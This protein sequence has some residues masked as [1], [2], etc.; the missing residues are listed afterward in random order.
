MLFHH[1]GLLVHANEV[2]INAQGHHDTVLLPPMLPAPYTG[3][4]VVAC[5]LGQVEFLTCPDVPRHVVEAWKQVAPRP[6]LYH[7]AYMLLGKERHSMGAG[8]VYNEELDLQFRFHLDTST[9]KLTQYLR[10]PKEGRDNT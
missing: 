4:R 9:G 8:W 10:R 3:S 6:V 1:V 5:Y 7:E 2:P